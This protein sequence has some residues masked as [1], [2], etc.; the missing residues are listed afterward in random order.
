[1]WDKGLIQHLR[2]LTWPFRRVWCVLVGHEGAWAYYRKDATGATWL[3]PSPGEY[4]HPEQ[5]RPQWGVQDCHR[6]HASRRWT[7]P[8]SVWAGERLAAALKGE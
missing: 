2:F 3:A 8:L 4:W 6:C 7:R 5:F 1:M